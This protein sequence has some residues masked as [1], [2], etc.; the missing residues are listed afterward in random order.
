MPAFVLQQKSTNLL[1]L[2]FSVI[3]SHIK[4]VQ[5]YQPDVHQ[6]RLS[7]SPQ[8]PTNPGRT[9]L[10]L[11]TLGFRRIGFSPIFSLLTPAYSLLNLHSPFGLP[12][13]IKYAPLPISSYTN[14]AVSVLCLAPI[15]FRRR[16]IRLVSYYALF[17]GWLLLSQ[18]PSCLNNSTSFPTQH[19][20]R[21][22]NWRSG[23]FPF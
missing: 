4:V 2:A 7:A 1:Q 10:P 15:H 21:D 20:F 9:T 12:S 23:L 11:E 14:S 5:E 16:I 6:L 18:P 17:K 19:K 8:D 22:L 3:P 13:L